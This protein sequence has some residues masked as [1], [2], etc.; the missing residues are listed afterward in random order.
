MLSRGKLQYA[1]LYLKISRS[2]FLAEES[3]FSLSVKPTRGYSLRESV[4]SN[5][6]AD[7]PFLS[8]S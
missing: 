1:Q 8:L 5:P 3:Q 6:R 7:I 2:E 4:A